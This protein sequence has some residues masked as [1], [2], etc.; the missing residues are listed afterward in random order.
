MRLPLKKC[1]RSVLTKLRIS[2]HPLYIE[3]G[4]YSKPP[5]PKEKRL[6]CSCRLFIEDEKHFVLYCSKYEQ[7]RWQ[8]N[9]LFNVNTYTCDDPMRKIVNPTNITNARR[10]CCYLKTCFKLRKENQ[11]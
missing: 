2:A 8:Y 9:D 6:C 4:R 10:T 3:T 11:E 1:D 5:T 7:Y